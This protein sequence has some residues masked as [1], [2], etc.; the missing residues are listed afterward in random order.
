VYFI[1]VESSVMHRLEM[2]TTDAKIS[3][4]ISRRVAVFPTAAARQLFDG[5]CDGADNADL[6][7]TPG[8]PT[9][10]APQKSDGFPV[11]KILRM[12]L[13]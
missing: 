3:R 1:V 12:S 9:I 8:S 4:L 6:K 7:N 10:W 5:D 2:F 13:H 11:D